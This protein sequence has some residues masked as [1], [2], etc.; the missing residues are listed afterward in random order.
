MLANGPRVPTWRLVSLKRA[1]Q[2]FPLPQQGKS[3]KRVTIARERADM[4]HNMGPPKSAS[5]HRTIPIGPMVVNTL[6]EW[7][8]KCPQSDLGLVFPT[9]KGGIHSAANIRKRVLIP[10]M[11]RAGIVDA[12]GEAKYTGMHAL[13]HFYASWLI[14]PRDLGGLGLPPKVV[15]ERLG[16]AT[17]ALTMD[18]YSHLFPKDAD[19]EQL[20]EAE[21]ALVG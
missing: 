4:Y 11:K 8:L 1:G 19:P 16:H 14:N 17:L 3:A 5:G 7:K 9:S 10:T 6:K 15:Q 12:D 2:G 21:I 20:R 18:T 13:R